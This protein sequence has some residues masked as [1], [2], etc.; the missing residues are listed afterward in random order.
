M[1]FL[2]QT[3]GGL[4]L[5]TNIVLLFLLV[6]THTEYHYKRH[7]FFHQAYSI[8]D[9]VDCYDGKIEICKI[10][11]ERNDGIHTIEISEIVTPE[12]STIYLFCWKN[13]YTDNPNTECGKEYSI[14]LPERYR[15]SEGDV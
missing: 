11:I 6:I 15:K 4:F 5:I 14:T 9:I 12:I 10:D 3:C 2:K 13:G 1:K 8:V 7:S